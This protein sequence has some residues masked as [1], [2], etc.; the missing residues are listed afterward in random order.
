VTPVQADGMKEACPRDPDHGPIMDTIQILVQRDTLM[1]T[2]RNTERKRS[3]SIKKKL[4][5]RNI[6]E[7][8]DRQKRGE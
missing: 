5:S 4:K 3:L 1:V 6:A 2:I 7:D 8:T